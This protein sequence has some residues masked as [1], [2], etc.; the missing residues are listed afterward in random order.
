MASAKK[1]IEAKQRYIR[2]SMTCAVIAK[3]LQVDPGTVYRWKAE[4]KEKGETFDWD[5]QRQLHCTSNDEVAARYRRAMAIMMDRIDKD[6]TLLADPKTADALAKVKKAMER[7]DD[8]SQ[9][10]NT[11]ITFVKIADR[12][13]SEYQPELKTKMA[14]Y[15]DAI[16]EELKDYATRKG[17]YT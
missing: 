16:I 4:D 8:R 10:L 13:L 3:E 12:W 11:I 17:R 1:R 2:T 9:Y 6:P 5:Y 15:W 7:I 14:P